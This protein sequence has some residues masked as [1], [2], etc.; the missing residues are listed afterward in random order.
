MSVP[1]HEKA[2]AP[3][4][5]SVDRGKRLDSWKEIATYLGRDVRTIQRWETRDDLPV[6]RLQHSKIGSVFAYTGELDAWRDARDQ[7]SDEKASGAGPRTASTNAQ[8]SW[9]ALAVLAAAAVLSAVLVSAWAWRSTSGAGTARARLHSVAVLPLTDLS[10]TRAQTYF[11][12]GMTEALIA[13]LSATRDLRVI[14]HRS[15]M[16]FRDGRASAREIAKALNVD[17]VIEGSVLREGDRV[18]I[19]ARLV[20]GDTQEAVW[21][22]TYDRDMR[23]VL[24]LQGAVA[25]AILREVQATVAPPEHARSVGLSMVAPEAYES[26]LKARFHLNRRNRTPQDVTE[27]IRLFEQTIARDAKFGQAYAGLAA[28]HQASGSTTTGV[29]PV[30]ET[31]PKAV[32][33]ARRAL[34]LDP[35]IAEA[36][37]ILAKAEEQAWNWA[38]AEARYRDALESDPNDANAYL[39]LGALLVHL[40]RTEEGLGLA[41][42]GRA[43]D[44]LSPG[45]TVQVG[46]LLYHARRYDDAI[47]EL[48]IALGADSDNVYAL[49]HLGFALLEISEH[50]EAIRTIERVAAM[51]DRNPAALGILAR[52]Y[53]RAG[54]HAE[55]ARILGELTRRGR[56]AYIPPAVFVNAYIGMGDFE[57]G[58]AALERAYEEHSNIIQF[59]KTHPLFDPIR[60]DPRFIDLS[61][62]VG[63]F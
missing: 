7:S 27:G 23:D 11:V 37:T 51:W 54:K 61:R 44:P 21:S 4:N 1:A 14:A 12:D 38:D 32:A 39:G 10:V 47:R 49:W 34:E 18:R 40:G 6:H 63:L 20:R 28:A 30:A 42:R 53:G 35:R 19:T 2:P 17:A 62:R 52:A 9:R 3:A 59:L 41:R 26:Y 43:L 25:D 22:G 8:R 16:Q 45:S 13:R 56:D 46:W 50:E 33:A 60:N 55:A 58:I 31:I 5:R 24:T 29:L 36:H 48:R 15:V 57:R